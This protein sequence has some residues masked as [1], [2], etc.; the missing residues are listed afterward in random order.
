MCHIG[1]GRGDHVFGG[2]W[3]GKRS[4]K[5]ERDRKKADIEKESRSIFT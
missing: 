3:E 2:K 5:P 4:T 1:N